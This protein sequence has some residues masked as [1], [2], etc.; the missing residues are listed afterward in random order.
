MDE[1]NSNN[2]I[3]N[4]DNSEDIKSTKLGE[5][6]VP[7]IIEDEMKK[8]YLDYAMS[9][10]VGRA[11]PD[12]RDGLKPVHRRIL[13]AMNDMGMHH[14]KAFKKSARIVGEVLGK[15]HPHGDSAVYES[16]VRMV[17]EFSLRYPLIQG[18]GNFGSVD[19]DSAAA[20]RY[21]E[22]RMSKISNEML[23]DIEKETVRMTD[24]F[25]GSL[26][27]PTVLPAKLPNL[28]IN[29][30][31]GIAVGMA[32]NMPPHNLT[33]VC[34]ATKAY[35]LN[36]DIEIPELIGHI[37]GP[38][39]PTGATI[40]GRT[41]M[42]NAY[43]TGRG[44]VIVKAK[45][46]MEEK[47]NRQR[48][49]IDEIPYQVNK[50]SVIEEIAEK[51]K[52]KI[53]EGIS[54]L[55]DE[56]DRDGMRVVIELKRDANQEVVVNQL[57]KYTR[58]KVT[59][60]MLM[61]AL[62]NN[63]PK[64]MDLKEIIKHY[65]DHRVQMV[66]KRTEYELRKA[67]ERVHILEGLIIALNNIDE[68]VRKIKESKDGETARNMLMSDYSLSEIQAR[69]ILDMKLQKL[70]G[71]EQDKIRDE[72]RDLG[73]KITDLEDILAKHERIIEIIINELDEIVAAYGNPRRTV[74][75]D[76][77]DEDMDYEQL[78]ERED[79]VV[80]ISNQG[81]IKRIPI[82]TYKEQRRGGKGIIAAQTKEEDFVENLFIA[83][84]HDYILFFT[85]TGQLHWLK[86]YKIPEGSRQSK[87]KPIINLINL[88]EGENI[89][90]FI[91]IKEFD[92]THYLVMATQKGVVKKTKLIE[93]S[94]PRAG[95]IRAINLDEGDKLINTYLTD[96]TKK[97]IIATKKGL[98]IKFDETDAR[99]LGRVSRGV[100]G[101]SLREDDEVIG[102][103]AVE[104]EDNIL[105]ITEKGYGKRTRVEDY[106]L[107]NRGGKGVI[108]LKINDKTGD[109][110]S[111]KEVD[112]EDSLMFVTK[113][114]QIIRTRADGISTFGRQ[115]TGVR[116]MR[117]NEG[118]VVI[119][120]A[121]VVLE[122]EEN[123][124]GTDAARIDLSAKESQVNDSVEESSETDE[125]EE[126][127]T[128]N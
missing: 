11:L 51:V 34:E 74:I 65:C 104:D 85:N 43:H 90:A 45:Y 88:E 37:N 1:N 67:N 78:I 96:G 93:Y 36:N 94:R 44:K 25:D 95:G 102:M 80:T 77:D 99:P 17:Q 41:G 60:G 81:Y 46:H 52:D 105:T 127:E 28:L 71:L 63:Q 106:R 123:P 76:L 47:N 73:I 126:E 22:A 2:N 97:I 121:K 101:I 55:R 23:Q 61:L 16:I 112:D 70:S 75:D 128:D 113:N 89:S 58:L 125:D 83:N 117:M 120:A 18:Q 56:S 10:I 5:N 109:I 57:Y 33:E 124:A 118:D 40:A 32:T 69:S 21:T 92:D 87:G 111:I 79:M 3:E 13:F 116:I 9:V 114:G 8:S 20:M 19:G 108:N 59:F 12:V 27:E 64:V 26:K 29:G 84:T 53:I 30:S 31:S 86:V 42:N 4:N 119:S 49:I 103:I 54:D 24:N 39:F 82:N 14:N 122:D 100:R 98:A 110:V 6:I 66:T 48:I 7:Q 15:Y 68:V 115:A 38:D 35:L 72:H 62:T 91:P 50:A 107:I